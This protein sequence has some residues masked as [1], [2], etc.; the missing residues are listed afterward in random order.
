ME[1]T[2]K[3]RMSKMIYSIIANN[4]LKDKGIVYNL[5]REMVERDYQLSLYIKVA[6]EFGMNRKMVVT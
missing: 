5:R 4:K 6:I 1:K 2:T 3:T